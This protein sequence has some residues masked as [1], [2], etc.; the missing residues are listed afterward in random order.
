[1]SNQPLP[2]ESLT[3]IQTIKQND[4][5]LVV[6]MAQVKPGPPNLGVNRG[7]F[8][9]LNKLPKNQL[10]NLV[11]PMIVERDRKICEHIFV[12]LYEEDEK[13]AKDNR[14]LKHNYSETRKSFIALH[15]KNIDLE[16]KAKLQKKYTK[17]DLSDKPINSL[18]EKSEAT[19]MDMK[20]SAKAAP[21]AETTSNFRVT[22]A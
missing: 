17:I 8:E 7:S 9:T 21:K 5:D 20:P 11:N 1:M 4:P 19:D 14:R 3:H 22:S 2:K 13:A 12:K 15:E 10:E 16:T 18:R 6:E